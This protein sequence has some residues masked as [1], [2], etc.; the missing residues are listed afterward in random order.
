MQATTSS[1]LLT[2]DDVREDQ[3]IN[4]QCYKVTQRLVAKHHN[5]QNRRTQQLKN[6]SLAKHITPFNQST[7][8]SINQYCSE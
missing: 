2:T 6:Y 4:S 3:I 8:Q 7:D 1:V 5:A